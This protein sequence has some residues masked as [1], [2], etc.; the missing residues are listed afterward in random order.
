[1]IAKILAHLAQTNLDRYQPWLPI[2]AR[3]PPGQSSPN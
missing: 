1:V 2:E 3:A